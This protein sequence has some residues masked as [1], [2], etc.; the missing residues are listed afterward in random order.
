MIRP[1]AHL[2]LHPLRHQLL[3][4]VLAWLTL[5]AGLPM[6]TF[7]SPL[8]AISRV[9]F[10]SSLAAPLPMSAALPPDPAPVPAPP[11]LPSPQPTPATPPN[12]EEARK[13]GEITVG[14]P[15]IW[16]YERVNSLLDGLLRDVEGIS[17]SDLVGLD[18]NTPNGAAVKFVQSMLEIG[19]QYNQGAAVTNKIAMQNYATA[20]NVASAQ[21]QA[22]SAYLQ[23]LNQ[24]R[25]TLSKQLADAMELNRGLQTQLA[26]TLLDP[27][28]ADYKALAARQQAAANEVTSLQSDLTSVNSQITAASTTTMPAAPNLTSTTGGTAPES[29]N[30]FSSFLGN[31]PPDLTKNIVSQLQSPS[32]PATKRMDNFITLLYERLAREISVLQDDVMRDPDNVPFLV[33][34]DVGLYPGV[35]AKDHVGVVEFTMNCEGCKVYS[36]Y[37]GQSSYNLANYEGA[38]KRYSFWGNLATLVGLGVTADYR[39]Q[40]DTLHGD[41][42]QSVYISGFQEGAETFDRTH[43][44]KTQRFGWYYGAAPFERLVTPGIRST[45]AVISVPRSLLK[46]C[47]ASDPPKA[48]WLCG[49]G[50]QGQTD[51]FSAIKLMLRMTAHGDWMRRDDPFYQQK[52]SLPNSLPSSLRTGASWFTGTSL[53]LKK[54]GNLRISKDLAVVL[55]GTDSINDIP[56][57]VLTERNRLHVTGLEYS[58][59][60][61]PP[62]N[63]TKLAPATPAPGPGTTQASAAGTGPGN[64]SVMITSGGTANVSSSGTGGSTATATVSLPPVAT[65]SPNS[66]SPPTGDALTGCKQYECSALLVRLAEPIDPNLAVS[67]KGIP[68]RRVRDWR[69]RATSILPP[70]QSTSDM[71]PLPAG[72]VTSATLPPRSENAA[73]SALL[74]ADRLGP[75]TWME[76]DSHRLLINVSKNLAGTSDFPTIQIIDPTKRTFFLPDNLDQGFSE[77][78]M[79]DFHLPVRDERQLRSYIAGRFRV[80]GDVPR[81]EQHLKPSGP[82]AYGT[83]LPLFLPQRDSQKIDAYLGE[84]GVQILVSLVKDPLTS[85]SQP[86][87]NKHT[88]LPSRI[89]VILEDGDLDLAWSLSCYVQGPDLVCDV[90]WKEIQTSYVIVSELCGYG[91]GGQNCPSISKVS[92]HISSLQIWVEQYDPDSATNNSF[93]TREPAKLGRYPMG[94][95]N[96][97]DVPDKGFRSWYFDSTGQ[98]FTKA[99][100]CNYP[101]FMYDTEVTILGR[102]IPYEQSV[103]PFSSFPVDRRENLDCESFTI[104]TVALTHQEIALEYKGSNDPESL[105]ASRFQPY[106]DTPN[107]TPHMPTVK[108]MSAERHLR[109]DSWTV[110]MPVGRVDCDDMLDVLDQASKLT[111]K[112][113]VGGLSLAVRKIGDPPG[114]ECGSNWDEESKIGQI[115]LEMKAERSD[116]SDLPL[117][118]QIRILRGP[119]LNWVGTL[120]D[121]Q[122]MLLPR[123]LSV[124]NM[125]GNQFALEGEHAGEIDAVYILGPGN[126]PNPILAASSEQIALVTLADANSAQADS[127]STP[128]PSPSGKPTITDVVP[129]A[130]PIGSEVQIQG[131]NFGSKPGTV[132]FPSDVVAKVEPNCWTD[133]LI[134]VIVPKGTAK[135][136]YEKPFITINGINYAGDDAQ[137]RVSGPEKNPPT[138]LKCS[139]QNGGSSPKP[140]TGPKP[141]IYTVVPLIN[142]Q[143]D[144]KM[145][146]NYLRLDVLDL[147][148]KPLTFTVPEPPKDTGNTPKGVDSP[149]T[150]LTI[151]KKTTVTPPPSTSN[152]KPSQ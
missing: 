28:S 75:D 61:L 19:V 152:T 68:L 16:Q 18:P 122:S 76:V 102:H 144:P 32:L 6:N 8:P 140:A 135:S 67:V 90:P 111:A 26:T 104:P 91:G 57:V 96:N 79:N 118:R 44:R 95:Y 52:D 22:N 9:R 71:T 31:L 41:L 82:Y 110:N 73:S 42:I 69:G 150:T 14:Q 65:P 99:V 130:G 83:F 120:P 127:S 48:F 35:R 51:E 3:A 66:A 121:L 40:S 78:T 89:Q 103:R 106:Y 84:S 37:P 117:R 100:G 25:D 81:M 88:W 86:P 146:P 77:I 145:S 97:P 148:G 39:R 15:K 149:T 43:E 113:K 24:Q 136:E 132:T 13:W 138:T 115:T 60:Y 105:S 74:E 1:K 108:N 101:E 128:P 131:S 27:T 129:D 72:G 33:Q 5:A 70:V 11:P 20:Q 126:I 17:T 54:S 133:S 141:G 47:L 119:N 12:D 7:S 29:P 21:I 143:L 49:N 53:N 63:D 30:T 10:A 125:G 151:S 147:S 50:L 134:K 59:V 93:F 34:F 109:A 4:I 123:T 107:V 23:Q 142:T 36:I 62:P 55:P 124:V 85:I 56:T 116:L 58:P 2:P 80:E 92:D 114:Q 38:S 46:T 98:Y 139:P 137:F 64:S 87:L 94:P 45:F 112:W